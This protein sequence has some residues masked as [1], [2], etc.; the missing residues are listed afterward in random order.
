MMENERI[1]NWNKV[2]WLVLMGMLCGLMA[3]SNRYIEGTKI[4]DSSEAR[5]V[6]QVVEMY[7]KALERRDVDFLAAMVSPRYFEKNGNSNSQD[8]YDYNGLLGFLQSPEFR[9]VSQVR[10][11]IIYK[12][13]DF[14]NDETVATVTY[15]YTADFKM[16][17][18]NFRETVVPLGDGYE[19]RDNYDE[20]LWYSKNDQN[21]M[22]LEK[23]DDKWVILKG[24]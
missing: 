4:P 14:N 19:V 24:M 22:V 16:P 20:E 12:A 21:Q 10:M 11:K 1:M 6:I 13:V 17:P 8:N 18:Q 9:A 15:N 3:C 5:E 7:R 2:T 23:R